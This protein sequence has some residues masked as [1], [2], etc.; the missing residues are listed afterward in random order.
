MDLD[1]DYPEDTGSAME[2][3][4][5]D[6]PNTGSNDISEDMTL[7]E[8]KAADAINSGLE[9][10]GTQDSN[11]NTNGESNT[12]DLDSANQDDPTANSDEDTNTSD[13]N[14]KG[15]GESSD[16]S[17]TEDLIATDKETAETSSEE[18]K[19]FDL[20]D[21]SFNGKM[22]TLRAVG[23]DIPIDNLKEV[24]EL[25][26]KGV[27]FTE[28][29]QKIKPHYNVVSAMIDKGYSNEDMFLAMEAMEGKPE[30]IAEL[31][32]KANVEDLVDV[33]EAM[34]KQ[35]D[36]RA[37]N[38]GAGLEEQELEYVSQTILNDTEFGSTVKSNLNGKIPSEFRESILADASS[39]E[40]FYE[41]TKN[42]IFDKAK[43]IA[44]KIS[45]LNPEMSYE[46]AYIQASGQIIDSISIS[47]S[48]P[49][50]NTKTVAQVKK[51]IVKET[52]LNDKREAASNGSNNQQSSVTNGYAETDFENMNAESDEFAAM[53]KKMMSGR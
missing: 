35:G 27:K 19:V 37:A 22:P 30:A 8:A 31:M 33:E 34:E 38:R 49:S 51:T 13:T 36:Y 12:G 11:S 42:G 24:Y 16:G 41:H 14:T 7:E 29:M 21:E 18:L 39:L 53:Y 32:K 9:Q 5:G 45:L 20:N 6:V 26:S 46:A 40:V 25:A 47:N 1:N 50:V 3:T 4:S 2:G 17:A 44:D 48:K 10:S 28:T 52:E 15:D 43:P 23:K